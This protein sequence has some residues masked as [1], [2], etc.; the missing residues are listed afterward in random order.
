MSTSILSLDW[1]S[2]SSL[3]NSNALRILRVI[4]PDI[5]IFAVSTICFIIIRRLLIQS[6][7][8]ERTDIQTT[9]PANGSP[10]STSTTSEIRRRNIL[11]RI[12]AVIR[13]IR[14]FIQFLIL[15]CAAFIYPSIINSIYF[16]FFLLIAFV[17][18][19]SIK[20]GRKFA[21]VRALLVIYAGLHLLTLYLYQFT[22]FQDA[23]RP[24]SLL[25]K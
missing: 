7:R 10:S 1:T 21:L 6:R 9:D 23:F 8:R 20:F 16:I 18:S 2:L 24:L 22:F 17:W 14:L 12:L 19:L 25:S 13:R 4:F 5:I 11:R 3:D 15:G